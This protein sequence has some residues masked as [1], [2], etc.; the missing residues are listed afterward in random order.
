[1]SNISLTRQ[2]QTLDRVKGSQCQMVVSVKYFTEKDV[3][4]MWHGQMDDSVKYLTDKSLSNT[5]QGETV[6]SVR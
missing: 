2:C 3:S 5:C 4:D 6:G 1:M